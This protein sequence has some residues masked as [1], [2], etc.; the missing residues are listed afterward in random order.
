MQRFAGGVA[1][2]FTQ[3]KPKVGP[4][5]SELW[6]HRRKE[7]GCDRRDDAHAKFAMKRLP[8]GS[9]HFRKLFSLAEDAD[10]LVRNLLS[11]RREAN[12]SAGALDKGHA[13]KCLELAKASR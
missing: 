8:F 2:F 1:G 9:R 5:A 7:E 13:E 11:K 3:V 4:L 12:Q 10:R 6:E